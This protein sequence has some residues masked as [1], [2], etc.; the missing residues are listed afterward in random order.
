MA[1]KRDNTELLAEAQLL[2]IIHHFE[3]NG[4]VTELSNR[5]TRASGRTIQRQQV[6]TWIHPDRAK[7]VQMRFGMGLLMI[8]EA[9]KMIAEGAR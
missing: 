5:I 3:K 4:G 1:K 8:Q 7:R 2:P 6:E 9:K